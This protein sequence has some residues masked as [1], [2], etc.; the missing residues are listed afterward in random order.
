M[1]IYKVRTIRHQIFENTVKAGS[2]YE[3]KK[4]AFELSGTDY[5]VDDFWYDSEIEEID[6]EEGE[7]ECDN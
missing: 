3:A 5:P 6:A 1:P 4:I 7:I 2:P